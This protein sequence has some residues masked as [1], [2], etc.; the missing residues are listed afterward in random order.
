MPLKTLF[1][2]SPEEALN[3]PIKQIVSM[4][5][6]GE[7]KDYSES[8]EELRWFLTQ[9]SSR[10]LKKLANQCL[11]SSFSNSG[12]A[13]QDIINE[14][15]RRLG[16]D[17]QNGIYRGRQDKNNCDGIWKYE[18]R[19]FIVEVKTTDAYTVPLSKV[20]NYLST[21]IEE[22]KED[23]AS[24]LIVVGRQ[25]TATLED[26]L[27]GSKYNWNMRIVGV[28]ALFSAIE[29]REMTVDKSLDRQ[30]VDLFI[31]QEFTRIDKIISTAFEFATDQEEAGFRPDQI[32]GDIDST[33]SEIKGINTNTNRN[34]D[35]AFKQTIIDKMKRKLGVKFKRKRTSFDGGNK[36]FVISVSKFYETGQYQYWYAYSL[37]QKDF[38]GEAE[39]AYFILGCPNLERA[40]AI[41]VKD[42]DEFSVN[43]HSYTPKDGESEK[44]Y[45]V[46]VKN[47]GARYFIYASPT[48]AEFDINK[49][50]I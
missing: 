11:T 5:G 37:K 46:Y 45:N 16:M 41:P 19:I 29:L 33:N 21:E 4:A 6:D 44:F 8:C 24:C 35:E 10:N 18:E 50:E 13:L 1:E 40:F 3:M 14:A 28:E 27:R 34:Q 20:A 7:L 9:I 43:M 49:F 31:P 17:V 32:N 39:E 12:F 30:I 47:E 48:K 36:R 42:M 38:L 2:N 23:N 15:G 26:Q 22:G 25:D